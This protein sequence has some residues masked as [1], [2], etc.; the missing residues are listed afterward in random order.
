MDSDGA[1]FDSS[2]RDLGLDVGITR[3]DFLNASLLATGA[4]VFFFHFST[5]RRFRASGG[6]RPP[7]IRSRS[8]FSLTHGGVGYL[9]GVGHTRSSVAASNSSPFF[10]T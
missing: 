6:Y 2:E 4:V 5:E 9:R 7:R 3:R 10:I 8:S 1:S